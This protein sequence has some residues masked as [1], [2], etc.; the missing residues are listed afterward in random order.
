MSNTHDLLFIVGICL[1]ASVPA[2]L[3]YRVF[4]D[5]EDQTKE[6]NNEDEYEVEFIS[7]KGSLVLSKEDFEQLKYDISNKKEFTIL[8]DAILNHSDI[9]NVYKQ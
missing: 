2:M 9:S 1:C 3:F 8:D 4:I 5:K 7:R 6:V